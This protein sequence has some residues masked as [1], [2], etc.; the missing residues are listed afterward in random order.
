MFERCRAKASAGTRC[1][2]QHQLN[3]R[4]V[5][6]GEALVAAI[7]QHVESDHPDIE[8]QRPI[9]ISHLKLGH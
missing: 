1:F 5:E 4:E 2:L 9:E 3:P 6:I 7:E 8:G